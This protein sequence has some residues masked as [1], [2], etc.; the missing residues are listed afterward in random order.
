MPKRRLP[1][2]LILLVPLL[3]LVAV[4]LAGVYRFSMSDEDIL[5]KFPSQSQTVDPIM[6]QLFSIKTPNPWVI[7]V[8]ET[9]ANAFLESYDIQAMWA[10]GLYDD[11]AERGQVQVSTRWLNAI[12]LYQFAT[13]VTVSNQGSGL[14]YYLVTFEYDQQRARMVMKNSVFL[15]DRITVKSLQYQ[16]DKLE[17]I[18]LEH[19]DSQSYADSPTHK[20]E[21]SFTLNKSL[22]LSEAN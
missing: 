3:L 16:F 20:V 2:P 8:P 17:L 1:I 22:E 19:S 7:T 9:N 11:G 5:S 15:G 13:I 10:S 14:F 4:I 21:R 18:Y 6:L 12:D